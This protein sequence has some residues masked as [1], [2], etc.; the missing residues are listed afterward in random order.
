MTAMTYARPSEFVP[1]TQQNSYHV[2]VHLFCLLL[3]LLIVNN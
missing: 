1:V 3:H 2:N